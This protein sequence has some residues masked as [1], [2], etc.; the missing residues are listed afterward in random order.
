MSETRPVWV[1]VLCIKVSICLCKLYGHRVWNKTLYALSELEAIS[2]R[3]VT[4]ELWSLLQDKGE[5]L[6]GDLLVKK[7]N[8]DTKISA[9]DEY[10]DRVSMAE[11]SSLLLSAAKLSDQRTFTCMVV[12]ASDI[13]EYPINLEILSEYKLVTF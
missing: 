10:K 9:T 12:A 6:S 1:H 4:S 3:H 8:E 2:D 13:K 7:A 5:G 11:N